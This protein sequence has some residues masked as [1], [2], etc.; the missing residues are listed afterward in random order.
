MTATNTNNNTVT[1]FILYSSSNTNF[2]RFGGAIHAGYFKGEDSVL[3]EDTFR[4]ATVTDMD[5]L[6]K[7]TDK[8]KPTFRSLLL[9]G[10]IRRDNVSNQYTIHF[11]TIRTLTSEHN[12]A[13]RGMEPRKNLFLVV[14]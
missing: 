12:E 7:M 8:K 1:P 11:E 6:S 10:S 3:P 5:Q 13:G 14:Y 9:P 2:A 4:F